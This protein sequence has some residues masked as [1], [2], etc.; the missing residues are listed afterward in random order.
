MQFVRTFAGSRY[1]KIFSPK[2]RDSNVRIMRE[3]R[4]GDR[5]QGVAIHHIKCNVRIMRP[6]K[7]CSVLGEFTRV[8]CDALDVYLIRCSF[9]LKLP[10][11]V[12]SG[13]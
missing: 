8:I 12:P 2:Y 11:Y 3:R 4:C 1:W 13:P 5:F 10:V 6:N 9:T 7:A